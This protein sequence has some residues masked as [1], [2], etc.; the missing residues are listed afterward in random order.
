MHDDNAIQ[1]KV[2]D[3]IDQIR[4]E[5]LASVLNIG[6]I[7]FGTSQNTEIEMFKWFNLPVQLHKSQGK[8]QIEK[9]RK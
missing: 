8:K 4:H 9:Y 6:G 3:L 1:Q 2:A 7:T 5:T